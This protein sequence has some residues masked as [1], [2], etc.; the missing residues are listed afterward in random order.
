LLHSDPSEEDAALSLLAQGLAEE[1][2][3]A[4]LSYARMNERISARLRDL[5]GVDMRAFEAKGTLTFLAGAPTVRRI[6]A[7]VTR[8]VER[9]KRANRPARV[10]SCLGFG[11]IGWPD[12]EELIDLECQL[13]VLCAAERATVLCLYD[14]RQLA[15]RVVLRGALEAHPALLVR[16]RAQKNPWHVAPALQREELA[17]RRRGES[18]LRSWLA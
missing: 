3:C 9:A 4:F 16:G 12:D 2:A 8:V 13:T 1:A 5:H 11:E 15:G 14:A 18:R 17:A 10:V 6:I 7:D